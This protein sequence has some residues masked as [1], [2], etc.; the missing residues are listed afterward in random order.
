MTDIIQQYRDVKPK[1]ERLRVNIENVL[2]QIIDEKKIPLFSIESRLKEESSLANKVVRKHFENELEKVDDLCGVRVVCYYQEDIKN[3]CDIVEREFVVLQKDNKKDSLDDNQFGY[4]SY[5]YVVSLKEEWLSHPAA[6]G[7]DGV[8]AEI[9]IRT[10][11]M[12]TWAAISHKLLYKRENDVPAQ[13]KRQL[14]R[15]SALIELADEQFDAIKNVK[16]QLVSEVSE[17]NSAVQVFAELTSDALVYIYQ[18]YF[19]DRRYDEEDIPEI[20]EE[21]RGAGFDFNKLVEKVELCLPVLDE[22]EREEAT[23]DVES[24]PMWSFSGAIRTI[25]DLTSDSYFAER[26]EVFPEDFYYTLTKK[27]RDR[28]R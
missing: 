3:I 20:L 6:R 23:P 12:H 17:S 15:L 7:L 8:R 19:S 11:L 14:N 9:Q 22:F 28:L 2:K 13:F 18:R 4:T 26:L 27:Y 25:L 21:I 1:L 16:I 24:F 10:M 5:H